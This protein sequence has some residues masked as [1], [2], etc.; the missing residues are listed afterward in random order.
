MSDLHDYKLTMHILKLIQFWCKFF[1]LFV[2]Y[3]LLLAD[4]KEN[5][6][7]KPPDLFWRWKDQV[8]RNPNAQVESNSNADGTEDMPV[9]GD[10][11][12]SPPLFWSY[13]DTTG[14]TVSKTSTE[15]GKFTTIS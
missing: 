8:A 9:D 14:Q 7:N 4:A 3:G 5:A 1:L 6:S 15:H 11:N 10:G 13:Y 2:S 12:N